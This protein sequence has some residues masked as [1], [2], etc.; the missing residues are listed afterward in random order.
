L[1]MGMME[2]ARPYEPGVPSGRTAGRGRAPG[3]NPARR[4]V[5][6]RGAAASATRPCPF[7]RWFAAHAAP[8]D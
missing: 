8:P 6:A 3:D 4:A 7:I 2:M 1:I 5:A